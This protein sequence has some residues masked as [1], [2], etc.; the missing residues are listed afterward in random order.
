MLAGQK[1]DP[2]V[3]DMRGSSDRFAVIDIKKADGTRRR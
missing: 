2:N 3:W 1:I